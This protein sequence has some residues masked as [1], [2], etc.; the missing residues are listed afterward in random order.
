MPN[1]MQCRELYDN[2]RLKMIDY[3]GHDENKLNKFT[4]VFSLNK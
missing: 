1:L 4:F 2:R 3:Q